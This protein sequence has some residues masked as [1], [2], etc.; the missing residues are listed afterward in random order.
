MTDRSPARHSLH[1][2]IRRKPLASHAG[3]ALP[4]GGGIRPAPAPR[5][6][7]EAGEAGAPAGA[8]QQVRGQASAPSADSGRPPAMPLPAPEAPLEDDADL[9]QTEGFQQVRDAHR[10][11]LVEDYVELIA[12]LIAE[13][14]RARQV[15]IAARLGVAQPTVARMLKRLDRDGY[16]VL[17]PYQGVQLT[18]A[19]QA[20]AD[21]SRNRHQLIETFLRALG[22]DEDNAR[23]DAEG[24]E[25]HA[26]QATLDAFRRY[27]LQAGKLP[28]G[29]PPAVPTGSSEAEAADG[30]GLDPDERG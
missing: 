3:G 9:V 17:R 29:M 13:H 21:A 20:L 25:H 14:G 15:Q 27:L 24:L 23:R 11:E 22:V 30:V 7:A 26:S 1:S 16:L 12:D 18:Q 5:A 28:P 19:G 10:Y 6:G 8:D 4:A 2:R